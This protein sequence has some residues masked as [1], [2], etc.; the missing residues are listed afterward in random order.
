MHVTSRM[1]S[2]ISLV[3]MSS[4]SAGSIYPN[5]PQARIGMSKCMDALQDME[6]VWP[7]AAR[8]N[9]LLRGSSVMLNSSN[10]GQAPLPSISHERQKRAAE[11]TAEADVVY[12]RSQPHVRSS[13]TLPALG[14]GYTNT[15]RSTQLSGTRHDAD[16]A[17]AFGAENPADFAG[18][19]LSTS[20]SSTY[21]P[22][23]SDGSS[24]PSFPGTLSTS[25]L[26]QMYS[27]GLIDENRIGHSLSSTSHPTQS[28]L[29]GHES[30]PGAYAQTGAGRYPQFW[31]DYTSFPQLG[32][33]YNQPL[34]QQRASPQQ[35]DGM[36][37]PVSG[38]YGG[39]Y[40]EC[41]ASWKS[42]NVDTGTDNHAP[43]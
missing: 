38:Q 42:H 35:Q 16:H 30:G 13:D 4:H 26:P 22:W 11:D 23:P 9:E 14:E 32:M 20:Q 25:V 24:Y 37:L 28:R 29:S 15:W 27:T 43:S 40:S 41:P 17:Q 18:V 34:P 31:N 36:Y 21:Y 33:A 2:F 7:S 10:S 5:D 6:V 39:I 8:A 1:S 12:E 19:P 3:T